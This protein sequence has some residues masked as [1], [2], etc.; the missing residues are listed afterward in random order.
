MTY[1][2]GKQKMSDTIEKEPK[3][4]KAKKTQ[5]PPKYAVLF[6]DHAGYAFFCSVNILR[7][8]FNMKSEDAM[9]HV[10]EACN[11]GKTT[12]VVIS[13]EIAESKL[14]QAEEARIDH[15]SHNPNLDQVGFT[16]EP[17]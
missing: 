14:Q 1:S 16:I 8:V 10:K 2:Q 5:R 3:T 15:L 7:D 17:V 6:N 13:K 12:I 4:K 11:E 9:S